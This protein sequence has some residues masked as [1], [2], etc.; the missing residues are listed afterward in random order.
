M[1]GREGE[2]NEMRG[3]YGKL[4]GG[5]GSCAVP[6][7]RGGGVSGAAL[8]AGRREDSECR[9]GFSESGSVSRRWG[10][11]VLGLVGC[12]FLF[13][14][15]FPFCGRIASLLSVRCETDIVSIW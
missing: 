9:A 1:E 14:R 2:Q 8:R 11:D 15:P 5:T 12:R 13:A 4:A 3:N 7:V 10:C 6:R